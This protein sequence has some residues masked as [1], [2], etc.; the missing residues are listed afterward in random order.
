MTYCTLKT[1]TLPPSNIFIMIDIAYITYHII[2]LS[3]QHS[4]D[5][6]DAN[7]WTYFNNASFT[8]VFFCI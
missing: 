5:L 1:G 6:V 3:I 7:P 8:R 2:K 4:N